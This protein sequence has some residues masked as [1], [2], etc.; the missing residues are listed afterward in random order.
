M[1]A[2]LD[3]VG[4]EHCARLSKVPIPSERGSDCERKRW[5]SELHIPV[6]YSFADA[7]HAS[8]VETES[9]LCTRSAQLMEWDNL[10]MDGLAYLT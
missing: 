1:A 10:S 2:A 8:R 3:Y 7:G 9:R 4:S 5:L 6:K